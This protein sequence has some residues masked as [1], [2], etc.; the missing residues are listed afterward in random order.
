MWV[1]GVIALAA[2]MLRDLNAIAPL[3]TMFFLLTYA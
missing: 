2:L 3:V 1:T